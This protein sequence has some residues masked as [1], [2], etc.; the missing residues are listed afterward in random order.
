MVNHWSTLSKS[1]TLWNKLY[2][3][4]NYFRPYF[5]WRCITIN[6]DWKINEEI[7]ANNVRLISDDG[8]Q[9]GVVELDYAMNMSIQKQLD[10]VMISPN[11]QPPVCKLMDYGKYRFEAIKKEKEAKK[12]QKVIKIK[13]VRLSP[14]IDTH[15]LEVRAKN[16]IKFLKEGD[17]VKAS[18]RFKGRQMSYSS[19]GIEVMNTFYEMIE[20]YAVMEKKPVLEGRNMFMI[21]VPKSN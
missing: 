16:A 4:A 14:V 15:D 1:V 17:K 2:L 10:L 8:E 12:K 7:R 11:A 21:L 5:F 18:I 13:E 19:K 9:L 20:E 6:N 3:W